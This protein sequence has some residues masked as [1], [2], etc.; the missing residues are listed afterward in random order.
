MSRK[1]VQGI[2]MEKSGKDI[3]LLTRDGEFLRVPSRGL[4]YQP[5]M[6]VEVS[7]PS[8]KR[9]PFMLSAACAAVILF[10]AVALPLLQPALATPEAYLALDINP[11][12]V[13]SLDEHA[14]VLEAK[15]INKDGERILEMLEAEGAQVLQVL[16]ALLEAAWENNYLAAGRDNIIIIS[17]AAPE[18]FGIGEED[19]CFSVSEQLLKLGVDTYLRVTVTGLDKFEAAEQMDIPLNALLLGEN[20]KATMQSEISRSLLEGTPPLPVKD[21]LQTVEPANI[22][23]QHEFFDG[24]GQ[25]DGRK[26]QSPPVPKD[27]PPQRNDSTGDADQD[28]QT[29]DTPDPPSTGSDQEKPAN[30]NDSGTPTP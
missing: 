12:V 19:L 5:G 1:N 9:L 23:E 29:E 10:I 4:S 14:V 27:V 7:I 15:A 2:V 28:E 26:P 18:N 11:G 16:D 30:P 6:E 8:R 3:I 13:F 17:L 21:F 20:I 24:R 25:K 22:F